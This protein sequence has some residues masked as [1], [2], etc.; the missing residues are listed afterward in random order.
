MMEARKNPDSLLPKIMP[1]RN[2]AIADLDKAILYVRQHASEYK[3]DP[4][5]TGVMGFLQE[6]YWLLTW[7]III[8]R[9]PNLILLHRSIQW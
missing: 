3:I 4:K 9:I 1:L 5:R 2:M 6:V 7:L 8:H